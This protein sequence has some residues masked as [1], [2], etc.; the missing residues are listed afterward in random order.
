MRHDDGKTVDR[1]NRAVESISSQVSGTYPAGL[2]AEAHLWRR[3]AKVN[4]EAGEVTEALLGVVGE[5]PRKG[6]TAVAVLEQELLDVAVAALGA[7]SHLNGDKRTD[8]MGRLL[9]HVEW[10]DD[11]LTTHLA[12]RTTT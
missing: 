4:E 5:N 9:D 6:R 10:V 2:D 12:G 3:C 8:V 1:I 7:V 11:R